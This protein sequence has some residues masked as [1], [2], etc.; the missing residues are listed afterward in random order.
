MKT[1]FDKI[2]GVRGELKLPGD[3][4]ISHRA[5]M[6]ACMA[7]GSS[8]I[9]NL[10]DSEDVKSTVNCFKQLGCTFS[11]NKG[12][13]I[14]NGKGYKNF[15][16][17]QSALDAGNSGTTARLLTGILSAQNFKTK[18]IGDESLSR[19]PMGR[20]IEPLRKMGAKITASSNNTLPLE[21]SPTENLNAI[22][23]ELPVPSA[24]VKSAVLLAGLHL[25]T[26]TK[27]I[28]TVPSRNHTENL[29]NLKVNKVGNKT[30]IF[31]SAENYPEPKK[32]FVPSDISSAAFFIVLTLLSEKG[33]LKLKNILLNETRSGILEILVKMGGQITVENIRESNKEKYGDIVV[34][35]GKL[36]NIEIPKEIIPNIID[37]I[38]VLSLA[39]LFA[40]GAFK[41]RNCKE[42]RFK[43]SDRIKALCEN[44]KKLGVNVNEFDDGFELNGIASKSKPIFDSFGDHRIAMTF[45]V[46]S[47]LL[48]DGGAVENFECVK[49][50]N[51]DFINQLRKVVT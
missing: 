49:I 18:I 11:E 15:S 7:R 17:P 8:E 37:E 1:E 44:Y 23:Y 6:F 41:I 45:A 28:E 9:E 30:V 42:L 24:Q 21:I 20:I 40:E 19:R 34:K 36:R 43:E 47:M 50:S 27:V 35:S 13:L 26:E 22:E 2:S 39:G 51:P 48:D 25:D 4:S 12:K 32:Y 38:P 29:L 10:S 46:A 16:E 31:S 5:V 3:K 14:I 33:E